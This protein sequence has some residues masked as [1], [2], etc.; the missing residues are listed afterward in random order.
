MKKYW[1]SSTKLNFL[2]GYVTSQAYMKVKIFK[3]GEGWNTK[4]NYEV[5]NRI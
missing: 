2:K 4:K 5:S 1:M 3:R